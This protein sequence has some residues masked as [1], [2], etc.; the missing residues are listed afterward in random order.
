MLGRWNNIEHLE[1]SLNLDEVKR[2]V[3][4]KR[5][6]EYRSNRF[7]AALKGVDLDA[8]NKEQIQERFDAVERRARAKLAGLSEEEVGRRDDA[9]ILGLGY[10]VEE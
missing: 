3:E 9:D 2:I 10:E 6:E 7:A 5:D 8:Q 1:D 4:A